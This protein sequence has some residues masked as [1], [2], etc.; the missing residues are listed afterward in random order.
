MGNQARQA[1]VAWR[2]GVEKTVSGALGTD[3]D[4][5]VLDSRKAGKETRELQQ[6]L[7]F[8][9]LFKFFY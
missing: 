5:R 2:L 9:S 7:L 8:G 4:S 3:V 6:V 1:Q